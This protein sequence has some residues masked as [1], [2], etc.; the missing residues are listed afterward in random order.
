MGVR[1]YPGAKPL[2]IVVDTFRAALLTVSSVSH[3]TMKD[4]EATPSH[5]PATFECHSPQRC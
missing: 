1:V 4:T 5:L 3:P 2:K